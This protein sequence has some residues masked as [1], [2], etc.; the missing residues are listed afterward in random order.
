MGHV[1]YF[2]IPPSPLSVP[3]TLALI[4]STNSSSSVFPPLAP[5]PSNTVKMKVIYK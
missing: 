5:P 2:F 3:D 1:F 4:T